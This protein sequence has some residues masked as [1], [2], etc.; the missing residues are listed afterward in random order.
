MENVTYHFQI[1]AFLLLK[2]C[3]PK[4]KLP[5]WQGEKCRYWEKGRKKVF[6]SLSLSLVNLCTMRSL[7]SIP[8][9]RPKSFSTTHRKCISSFFNRLPR[10]WEWGWEGTWL[11]AKPFQISFFGSFWSI[12][13]FV[14]K[15][16]KKSKS[17]KSPKK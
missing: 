9:R 2:M 15:W 13:S 1:T 12:C 6:H 4:R 17:T 3:V 5:H 11:D 7:S 16:G 14:M 10:N 8:N